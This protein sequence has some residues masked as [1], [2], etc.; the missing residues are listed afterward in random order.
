MKKLALI[1]AGTLLLAG[2]ATSSSI[3]KP[4]E[5]TAFY[6]AR[7]DAVW[8]AAIATLEKESIPIKSIEKGKGLITTKF[9]NYAVGSDAHQD[10]DKIAERPSIRL[11]IWSQVGYALTI[12]VTPINNMTTKVKI[13]AKIEAYD[14]N[15]T[16]N[17]HV[18]KTNKRLEDQLLELIR[19]K[20]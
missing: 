8:D 1:I 15:V 18:C 5:D 10:L 19:S 6:L 14:K 13:T 4:I 16:S 20:I 2:C 3:E 7:F 12:L 11:A 17:W 9:V